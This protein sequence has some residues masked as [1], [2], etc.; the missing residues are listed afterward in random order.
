MELM[1]LAP[2]L[3]MAAWLCAETKPGAPLQRCPQP[4]EHG[5]S[6]TM[7]KAALVRE[8]MQPKV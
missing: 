5:V 2:W 1:I 7:H 4:A 3:T 8:G 6:V